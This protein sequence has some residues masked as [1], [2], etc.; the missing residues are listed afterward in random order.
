MC[1]VCLVF[2]NCKDLK[3]KMDPQVGDARLVI[4]YVQPMHAS[5]WNTPACSP[6]NKHAKSKYNQ[7][8]GASAVQGSA[9]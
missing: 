1:S 4:R 3:Q 9:A 2:G 6:P 8:E 5:Q 7:T